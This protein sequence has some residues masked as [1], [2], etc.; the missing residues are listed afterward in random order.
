MPYRVMVLLDYGSITVQ[1][2]SNNH[3]S[4]FRQSH[5]KYITVNNH[6][7]CRDLLDLHARFLD[8][9]RQFPEGHAY[10]LKGNLNITVSNG[11]YF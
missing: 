7:I 2:W 5:Y 8:E 1:L 3:I 4:L 11:P 9:S 10:H 6:I